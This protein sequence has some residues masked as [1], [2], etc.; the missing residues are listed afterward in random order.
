VLQAALDAGANRVRVHTDCVALA[1]LWNTRRV[2]PRL[3]A[4]RALARAFRGF[5]IRPI[6][7]AHNRPAN[8]LARAAMMGAPNPTRR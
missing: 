5:A 7:R 6:P 1:R 2:D 4:V 3:G 8:E